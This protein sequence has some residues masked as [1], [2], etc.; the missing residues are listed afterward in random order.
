MNGYIVTYILRTKCKKG[1]DIDKDYYEVFIDEDCEQKSKER[2][3]YLCQGG[4]YNSNKVEIYS[5]NLCLI[6]KSTEPHYT[7]I[8]EM[9]N[10]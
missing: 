9:F 10:K 3:D 5:V 4:E 7:Y 8:E 2:Y 6:L 1:Q